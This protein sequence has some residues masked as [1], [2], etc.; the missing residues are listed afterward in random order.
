MFGLEELIL[1]THTQKKVIYE[2]NCIF[3]KFSFIHRLKFSAHF[4]FFLLCYIFYGE[5]HLILL[6]TNQKYKLFR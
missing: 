2:A 6:I 5:I 4:I 3:Q 1:A